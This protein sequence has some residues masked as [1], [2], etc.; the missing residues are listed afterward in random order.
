MTRNVYRY[1]FNEALSL[2]EVRD[3]LAVSIFAAEGM[4]GQAQVR[5]HA[6]YLMDEVARV[7]VVDAWTPVGLTVVQVFTGLLARQ[8]G[9]DAFEVERVDQATARKNERDEPEVAP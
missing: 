9:E 8:F 4:H 1:T 5:L 2:A 3:S 7:C 6:G